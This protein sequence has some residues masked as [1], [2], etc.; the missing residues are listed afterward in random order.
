M[1]NLILLPNSRKLLFKLIIFIV[2]ILI[3]SCS[4]EFTK[5][6]N[7]SNMNTRTILHDGEIREYA[8]FVPKSYQENTPVPLM[9]NFHGGSGD[10]ASQIAIADMRSIADT[11]GFILVYPQALPDPNDGGSTNWLQKDPT[12]VDDIYFVEAMIDTLSSE[13][14]IDQNR[15]Y[16]CGYSLGGEFSFE[17]ACRLS[18]RIAA[19]GSVARSMGT[20]IYG[21]CSPKHPTAIITIHGTDD[22]Y[23]GIIWQGVTYYVSIDDVNKYWTDFN[24]TDSTPTVVQL[25]NL[26]STDG[27]TVEHYSWNNGNGC[28]SV[29]HFEVIGGGH[30][31]PG[32]FGN[33]DIDASLEIWNFVSKYDINGLIGCD[34]NSIN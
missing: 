23:D 11:A 24:N 18:D 2:S 34:T 5:S 10:I 4:K 32:S 17:L 12:T 19:V 28:V 8:V 1:I 26:N 25:P 20:Y 30:D 27:S 3:F 22:D 7:L 14:M 13:Y 16:A 21:N 9:F 29:E 33:M 31:W 15:V 6:P